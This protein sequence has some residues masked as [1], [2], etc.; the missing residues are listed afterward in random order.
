MNPEAPPAQRQPATAIIPHRH[1]KRIFDDASSYYQQQRWF[2]T[3]LTRYEYALTRTVLLQEL[4]S[5]PGEHV[6]EIGCGPGTWTREV[7]PLVERLTAVDISDEMIRQARGYAGA[8][9][10]TFVH[11]DAAQFPL[12]QTYDAVFSVRVV[13]YFEDWKSVISRYLDAVAPGGRAVIITK[14]PISVYRGTGR[15]LTVGRLARRFLRR[16]LA[17]E[18]PDE[19]P[20]WQVYL[21]PTELAQLFSEHGLQQVKVRPV[22]YGLPIFM[23]GTKQ[24]P[25]VPGPLEPFF[26][27]LF[28]LAWRLAN[29]LPAPLR[30]ASLLFS[31]SYAVS[32]V[33][34]PT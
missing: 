34:P 14:T 18:Q 30:L 16:V 28:A 21:P 25:I 2:K 3:R 33:R 6:L 32:G 4:T 1:N 9:N 17:R 22:I 24:Y 27:I 19:H 13:E 23:R 11:S 7:A 15:Y 20:F 8:G 26:L 31:E 5:D 10:V 12:E 29:A